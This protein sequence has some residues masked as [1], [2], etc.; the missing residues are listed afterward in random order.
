MLPN[1]V[2]MLTNATNCEGPRERCL[3]G[4]GI[5]LERMAVSRID[6]SQSGNLA[7]KLNPSPLVVAVLIFGAFS[8]SLCWPAWLHVLKKRIARHRA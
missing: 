3:H 4:L 6:S 1:H 8:L 7:S 5:Y 2:V